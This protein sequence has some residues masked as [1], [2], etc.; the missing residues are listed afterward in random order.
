MHRHVALI[1]FAAALF[2]AS[3]AEGSA[4]MQGQVASSDSAA[5]SSPLATNRK[6]IRTAHI[7][8][9]VEAPEEARARARELTEK[10]G[11]Y[12]ER[13]EA[14]GAGSSK[15]CRLVLRIPA[16]DLDG[17]LAEIR[18]LAST[19]TNETQEVRDVTDRSID[20]E[21]RLTGLRTTEKQ[22]LALLED[23]RTREGGVEDVM[24]VHRE[25]TS[26]RTSIEAIEAERKSL[27]GLVSFA[28]IDLEIG[29]EQP[30]AVLALA[31]RPIEFAEQCL[32]ILVILF[33]LIA[34]ALIFAVVVV[35]PLALLVIIPLKLRARLRGPAGPLAAPPLPPSS[36]S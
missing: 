21:A 6:L 13:I 26:V 9:E 32:R 4:P 14:R 5:S 7:T 22:L 8:I 17:A 12:L 23:S 24:A 10:R 29:P 2:A 35:L 30:G 15:G 36:A 1:A 28:T 33:E 31:W 19:V 27:A 25:L 34:Y 11:G 18:K 20:I 16:E 3:C